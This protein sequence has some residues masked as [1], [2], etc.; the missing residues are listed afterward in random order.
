MP[1]TLQYSPPEYSLTGV[2]RG[3][4]ALILWEDE[5][6]PHL[7]FTAVP[8][9]ALSKASQDDMVASLANAADPSAAYTRQSFVGVTRTWTWRRSPVSTAHRCYAAPTAQCSPAMTRCTAA[10][11]ATTCRA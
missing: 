7:H 4:L 5:E 10:T 3:V 1:V 2:L 8:A 11:C 6:D 9:M